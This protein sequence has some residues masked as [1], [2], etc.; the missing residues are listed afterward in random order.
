MLYQHCSYR[1]AEK[2][3][4][5]PQLENR[6]EAPVVFVIHPDTAIRASL[7]SLIRSEGWQPKV[8]ADASSFL[9]HARAAG[10]GCLIVD[11]DLP[12][13]TGLDLQ[14]LFTDRLELP[15]IFTGDPADVATAVRAMKAGAMEFLTKPLEEALV[16]SA[17]DEALHRSRAALDHESEVRVLRERY[18]LLSRRERDV[19][20]R[21]ITGKLNKLIAEDLG[22]SIITVKAHRGRMMR[23]MKAATLPDLVTMA[24]RLRSGSGRNSGAHAAFKTSA[25]SLASLLDTSPAKGWDRT[26]FLEQYH[27]LRIDSAFR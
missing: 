27:L 14:Q 1:F 6:S 7:L 16:V 19:M 21:V 9:S 2:G 17:I 18:A 8:F 13:M 12:D 3:C 4:T 23:K 24:A 10:P 5:M 15:V 20:A 26:P 22:I 11:V 25:R